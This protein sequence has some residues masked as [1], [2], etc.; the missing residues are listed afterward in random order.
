MQPVTFSQLA[1]AF[2]NFK[3]ERPLDRSALA[4]LAFWQS[5]FCETPVIELSAD[6]VDAA[7]TALQTRG[8][9]KL[10]A[11]K[12]PATA[13]GEAMVPSGEPL[14]GSSVNRYLSTL[15]E[16][17][18]HA[19]RLRLVPRNYVS[20][21]KGLERAPE[22]VDP[23]RYLRP[24]QIEAII[25]AARL[26]DRKWGKLVA[27][28]RVAFVTGLRV[29]SIQALRWDQVDLD[30]R[31][32]HVGRTKNGDPITSVINQACVDELKKL[33]RPSDPTELIFRGLRGNRP[34]QF[35]KTWATACR[36][37]GLAGRNFHQV[38][39]GTGSLL[40]S[41]NVNQAGIMA[42]MGHR[43]LAASKRYIHLNTSDKRAITAKVF[44][45]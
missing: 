34:H 22:P 25:T 23:D 43:T 27:L 33:P 14:K 42:V 15:G 39:H 5:Q 9:L 29:G 20:P 7:L 36:E 8:R 40:A 19:S 12:N 41:S 38:R 1:D 21:L 13:R 28:T 10:A 24:E 32:I 18:K 2:V 45:E 11:G 37:A 26:I 44:G 4:R 3:R 16:V 6:Q 31:L 30:Q 17:L 35:R